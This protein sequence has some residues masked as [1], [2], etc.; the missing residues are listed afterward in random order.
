MSNWSGVTTTCLISLMAWPALKLQQRFADR[1]KPDM[2]AFGGYALFFTFVFLLKWLLPMDAKPKTDENVNIIGRG[3]L[4]YT[5]GLF[6]FTSVMSFIFYLDKM[7]FVKGYI[8]MYLESG[9]RYFNTS[10]GTL[11]LLW[12]FMVHLSLYITIIY[13][14]DNKKDCRNLVIY[15]G[16]TM[17][18]SV[19]TLLIAAMSGSYGTEMHSGSWLNI[20]YVT[21]S[22]YFLL[23]FL[24]QPRYFP[25]YKTYCKDKPNLIDVFLALGLAVGL[26]FNFVRGLSSLN[27]PF[28]LAQLYA[29]E[30]EPYILHPTNLGRAWM[31]FM[32]FCGSF[33]QVVLIFGLFQTNASWMLDWSIVYT[34]V[35]CH[36]VYVHL[37]PQFCPGVENI[38]HIPVDH[39]AF[40]IAAN[41]FVPFVALAT[42]LRSFSIVADVKKED[43]IQTYKTD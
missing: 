43:D 19:F 15:W 40:V 21:S 25:K 38:Y 6:S 28:P 12:D 11:L 31:L 23:K 32:L 7:G 4:Y 1:T 17:M 5:C 34:A 3:V 27:S 37:I 24:T 39:T 42:M 30:Y 18:T 14:I 36:G 9:E 2:Q 8:D 35:T 22:I 10:T 41:I 16:C 13:Y 29:L 26:I 20:P 33:L